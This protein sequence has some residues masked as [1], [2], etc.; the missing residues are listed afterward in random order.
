MVKNTARTAKFP[1]SLLTSPSEG[2]T[3]TTIVLTEAGPFAG[4]TF[5]TV[6]YRQCDFCQHSGTDDI[7]AGILDE[8]AWRRLYEV[9]PTEPGDC[10]LICC[11]ECLP[12]LLREQQ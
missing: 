6:H 4:E 12:E 10:V 5:E 8:S 11:E 2:A 3:V 9:S 1:L 7:Y